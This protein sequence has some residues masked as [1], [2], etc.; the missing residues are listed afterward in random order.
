MKTKG[1]FNKIDLPDSV[2]FFLG[3]P[4]ELKIIPNFIGCI[5]DFTVDG[6]E[7]L[8][9]AFVSKPQYPSSGMQYMSEC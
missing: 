7:P 4:P 8:T 3:T 6:R 5:R 9:N 1:N 2:G